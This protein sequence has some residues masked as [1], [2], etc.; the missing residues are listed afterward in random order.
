[1]FVDA[2][3]DEDVALFLLALYEMVEVGARV[4]HGRCPCALTDE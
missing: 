2:P 3:G 4:Y 1:M